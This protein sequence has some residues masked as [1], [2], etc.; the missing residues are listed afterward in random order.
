MSYLTVLLDKSLHL[1]SKFDCGNAIL[2]NYLK[3]QVGQDIRKNL[4]VCFVMLDEDEQTV[5]GYYTLSSAS[6]N[7][8][9]IPLSLRKKYPKAYDKIPVTLL[10]R[11]AVDV[12]KKG[13]GLGSKILIDALKRSYEVSKT[14]IGSVAIVVNPIDDLAKSYY[15]Y[16]GFVLLPDSEKMF[17]D[18]NTVKKL[19]L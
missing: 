4:A 2:N 10:G 8:T 11:L 6:I 9:K 5:I 7:S 13:K 18:M 12:N 15:E 1:R 3:T 17:L 16:F 14:A 19:D